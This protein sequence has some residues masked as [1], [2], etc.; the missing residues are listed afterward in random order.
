MEHEQHDGL[1]AQKPPLPGVR[2]GSLFD[3][4]PQRSA[5]TVRRSVGDGLPTPGLPVLAGASGEAVDAS[6]LRFLA[7]AALYSRKLEEEEEVRKSEEE[8]KKAKEKEMQKAAAVPGVGKWVELVDSDTGMTYFWNPQ[9]NATRWTLPGSSSSSSTSKRKKKKRRK[10]KT[11][12]TSSSARRMVRLPWRCHELYGVSVLG[13][14]HS[15]NFVLDCACSWSYGVML[16][17]FIRTWWRTRAVSPSMLAGFAGYDTPRSVFPSIV[18]DCGYST[19]AVLGQGCFP[20]R[21]C[22]STGPHGPESAETCGASTGAVLGQGVLPVVVTSGAYGQTVLKT[23]VSPQMQFVDEVVDISV[24]VQRQ[25]P[26]VL[27]RTIE[28]LRLQYTDKVI[29]VPVV[30]VLFP[31]AGVEKTAELPRSSW[32]RWLTCPCVQRQVPMTHFNKVVDVPV[33]LRVEVPQVQF[34][35][36]VVDIPA[37]NR[38]RPFPQK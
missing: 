22:A 27:F 36:D 6:T 25:F 35:A 9:T 18:D 29:D 14:E 24:V 20:A 28:L 10:K 13:S 3:P 34:I 17:T 12:K 15:A 4:G 19:G 8:E 31:S 21:Y 5:R 2:P 26:M 16:A 30:L 11:P 33:I 7:A 37:R 23:A 38:D 32:T 1:R